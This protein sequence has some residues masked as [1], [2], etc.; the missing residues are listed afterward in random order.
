M[1]NLAIIPA[2]GGSKRI[3]R[4]NIKLFLGKPI[5]AYSIQAAINSGLFDEVMVSTDDAEIAE[6]ANRYGA[7][8][9][10]MRSDKTSNDFATTFE[11]LEEVINS[12]RERGIE[13]KNIC[14]IYPC[15]PFVIEQKLKE[16]Y[17]LLIEKHFDAVFPVIQF[18]FPIQRALRKDDF[19]KI[20]FFYPEYALTRS[21]DLFPSFYDA[22]QFYWMNFNS[23][24]EQRKIITS[25][26]GSILITELEGQDIDNEIDWKIAE[27]KYEV[28]QSI[29]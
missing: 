1:S 11:V 25:N 13:F 22:G 7:T 20:Y 17:N 21:Q 19:G 15:A 27:L 23:C 28:L 18:G 5:M 3:P 9:P 24:M 29:K 12:Y 8:V 26:T 10:F 2:R 4:K 16:A 6:I 14:C